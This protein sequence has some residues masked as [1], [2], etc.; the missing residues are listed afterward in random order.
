MGVAEP[1]QDRIK[2]Y[3]RGKYANND[4]VKVV[5]L[6]LDWEDASSGVIADINCDIDLQGAENNGKVTCY[7]DSLLF[8]LY[9]RLDSFEVSYGIFVEQGKVLT[10]PPAH[11]L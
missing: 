5:Q 8:A 6:Y 11:A 4:P 10:L 2:Q 9:A 3:L 7:L 1:N